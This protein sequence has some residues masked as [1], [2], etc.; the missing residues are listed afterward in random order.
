MNE[1]ISIISKKFESELNIG[2]LK[3]RSEMH[4]SDGDASTSMYYVGAQNLEKTVVGT[5]FWREFDSNGF[6][7]LMDRIPTLEDL[8]LFNNMNFVSE[9]CIPQEFVARNFSDL[10]QFVKTG[11]TIRIGM[12][13]GTPEAAENFSYMI[14][15]RCHHDGFKILSEEVKTDVENSVYN[16][17]A[18]IMLNSD[19]CSTA[20]AISSFQDWLKAEVDEFPL[21]LDGHFFDPDT[22][23]SN[24]FIVR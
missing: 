2:G 5:M 8:K 13:W 12:R 22:D 4:L 1:I 24:P 3:I 9:N 17:R 16:Y 7:I 14:H 23:I 20:V 15:H 10:D 19:T 18:K 6:Y 21:V 11:D